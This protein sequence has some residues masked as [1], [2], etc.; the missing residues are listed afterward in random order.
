MEERFI[1]SNKKLDHDQRNASH[2][3]TAKIEFCQ[4]FWPQ[5]PQNPAANRSSYE[6]L[7]FV[8]LH[9]VHIWFYTHRLMH[10][11]PLSLC[12]EIGLERILRNSLPTHDGVK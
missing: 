8:V 7:A 11:S 9:A 12:I 3:N 6:P 5:K 10:S 2:R 1:R 4:V